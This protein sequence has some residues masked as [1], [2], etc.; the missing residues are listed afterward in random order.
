MSKKRDMTLIPY[1][2]IR[3]PPGNRIRGT[4]DE[5]LKAGQVRYYGIMSQENK[6]NEYIEEKKKLAKENAKIRRQNANEKKKDAVIKIKQA[7]DA[8]KKANKA[9]QEA[10]TA[11]K[12]AKK[13]AA[14]KT[15]AKK[16]K[17][18]PKKLLKKYLTYI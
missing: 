13:P 18:R 6:I 8:V 11:E 17:G 1:C 9:E 4:S 16:P 7:N 10:K 15:V 3:K 14:K 5:C 2:G 12:E